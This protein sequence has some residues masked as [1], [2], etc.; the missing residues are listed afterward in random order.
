[1]TFVA[2]LNTLKTASPLATLLKL[3][4]GQLESRNDAN[5]VYKELMPVLEDYLD[6]GYAFDSNEMQAI[7][8]LL[9]ELPAWG[10]QR[11]NFTKRYLQGLE[12]LRSLPKDPTFLPAGHWH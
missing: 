9:E 7:V 6:R 2:T 8:H 11:R 4:Y 5:R 12:G 10:T 3:M 1:M